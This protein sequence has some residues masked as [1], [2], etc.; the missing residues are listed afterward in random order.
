MPSLLLHGFPA[1]GL[2]RDVPPL[3]DE[4]HVDGPATVEVNHDPLPV[5]QVVVVLAPQLPLQPVGE[6]SRVVVLLLGRLAE[7]FNANGILLGLHLLVCLLQFCRTGTRAWGSPPPPLCAPPV[8]FGPRHGLPCME[9]KEGVVD[10]ADLAPVRMRH[11]SH[12]I[13]PNL[14]QHDRVRRGPKPVLADPLPPQDRHLRDVHVVAVPLKRP[15]R[16]PSHRVDLL[17]ASVPCP[18]VDA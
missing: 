15:G 12:G 18:E 2:V 9:R 10:H 11:G 6:F 13:L 8:R 14:W 7:V 3:P 1:Q 5:P 17:E 4:V 16:H